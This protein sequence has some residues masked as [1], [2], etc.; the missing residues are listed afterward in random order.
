MASGLK[1]SSTAA[2]AS[3]LAALDALGAEMDLF[4][5]AMIGVSAAKEVGVTITGALDA[6]ASM[7]GGV[8]VTDNREMKLLRREETDSAVILLVPDKKVLSKGTGICGKIRLVSSWPTWPLT[9]P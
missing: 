3:V 4:E 1:S 5:A 9:W 6:L 2:N 8:V 7:L